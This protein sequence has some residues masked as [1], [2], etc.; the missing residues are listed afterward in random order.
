MVF[1]E[2][3]DGFMEIHGISEGFRGAPGV[4]QGVLGVYDDCSRGLS[5]LHG[6]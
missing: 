1:Q 6:F 2:V 4:F 5:G 3:S